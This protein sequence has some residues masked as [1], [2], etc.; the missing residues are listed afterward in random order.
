MVSYILN[1]TEVPAF[2]SVNT[3]TYPYAI[4]L[5]ISSKKNPDFNFDYELIF[6]S[7]SPIYGSFVFNGTNVEN[8]AFES[9]ASFV[10]YACRTDSTSWTKISLTAPEGNTNQ[11]LFI[12]GSS[13]IWSSDNVVNINT[14]NV[15]YEAT[16]I[17][18]RIFAATPTIFPNLDNSNEYIYYQGDYVEGFRISA[19]SSDSSSGGI[20]TYQWYVV[21]D[22]VS[23]A[24]DGACNKGHMPNTS[25]L[26][27][28]QYY[29]VVTNTYEEYTATKSSN[30]VTVVVRT[31]DSVTPKKTKFDQKSASLGWIIGKVLQYIISMDSEADD[32]T[33]INGVLHLFNSEATLT[34]N[35][36]EVR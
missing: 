33:L 34:N 27:T 5:D 31:V 12:E 13:Y 16:D 11:Y 21:E 36:L 24:I 1:G 2:P 20:L 29:C 25:K 4:V 30:V 28:Y 17:V 6:I 15:Q 9:S 3:S 19:S 22:G 32:A 18:Q 7:T 10:G 26:G 35:N 14:G 23:K 8:V